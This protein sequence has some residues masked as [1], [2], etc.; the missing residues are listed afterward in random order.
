MICKFQILL[1]ELQ[2]IWRKLLVLSWLYLRRCWENSFS[3]NFLALIGPQQIWPKVGKNEERQLWF[4]KKVHPRFGNAILK[5]FHG[6]W[7]SS[8][9]Q[10]FLHAMVLFWDWAACNPA[11]KIHKGIQLWFWKQNNQV[12]QLFGKWMYISHRRSKLMSRCLASSPHNQISMSGRFPSQIN[13]TD[14]P[15]LC[16]VPILFFSCGTC[17]NKIVTFDRLVSGIFKQSYIIS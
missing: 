2:S 5:Q 17:H 6:S 3:W 1:C 11:P 7:F 16:Q 8:E 12:L 4:P 15:K 10:S 13:L 9:F 14:S